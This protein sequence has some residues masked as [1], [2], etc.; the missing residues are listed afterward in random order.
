[1]SRSKS[2]SLLGVTESFFHAYLQHTRGASTH[3]VRAYGAPDDI[4]SDAVLAFLDHVGSRRGNSA[5]T[6]IT[7][8][9]PFAV[10]CSISCGGM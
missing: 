2:E 5:V 9:Q 3:T 6:R 10:L 4:Q 1:M 7:G 8:L